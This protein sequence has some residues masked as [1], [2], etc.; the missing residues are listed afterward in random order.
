M[1]ARIIPIVSAGT[2]A[3]AGGSV[4]ADDVTANQSLFEAHRKI[5]P[6]AV[7][8]RYAAWRV[9]MVALT[10]L[11]FY[12]TPW[13]QWGGHQAV[14]FDLSQRKFFVFGLI[15]WPQDLIF[16]TGLLVI[17]ALSLFLFTAIAGRL[18]CGY[19]CPQTVYTEIFM[20]VER[21][22]E[23]DRV[24]RLKLD[25]APWGA[26]KLATKSAK[27]A[28]WLAI[29]LWTGYTFVGY[30]TPIR[31]LAGEVAM[32][33]TSSW[34]T[35]W[36]LFYGFATWGNA[37]FMREQVCK[38]MCP[39]A[40]FQS[41]MFD[42]NTLI[43][44]YDSRRGEQRGSR[45]RKADPRKLGLGDCVDCG[46]CVQVCPTGI[47]IRKGLQYECISCAACIDVC[48]SV[49]AKM[50]YPKGLIRHSTQRA[51][52]SGIADAQL[53]R[54]LLRPR[55]LIYGTLLAALTVAWL[56]AIYQRAPLRFDVIRDRNTLVRLIEPDLAENVYRLQVMNATQSLGR[57]HLTVAGLPGVNIADRANIDVPAAQS[58]AMVVRVRTRRD[59]AAPGS[60]PIEFTMHDGS[61]Q[62]DVHEKSSFFLPR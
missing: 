31:A 10:Q 51:L 20:W 61:H 27:H 1:S 14:L 58:Q 62:I 13:L 38:Y 12:G 23:G 40:R 32:L 22:I 9:A 25:A 52:E 47:D 5:Y 48:D 11:L 56:T 21:K 15:L 24:A 28:A 30:F 50:S 7:T 18:W 2:V 42:R 8:G 16:L 36:I 6:R 54:H 29:A 19:A 55:T 45:P 41:A 49:M 4:N 17:C 35:F 43:V 39:Y 3:N 26:R 37:G 33:S 59:A 57:Y 34:E 46:L 53:F 44:S 60:H